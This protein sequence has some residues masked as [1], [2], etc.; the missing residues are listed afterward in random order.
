[1][2]LDSYPS[3]NSPTD[4]AEEAMIVNHALNRQDA[5]NAKKQEEGTTDARG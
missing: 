1:M 3:R 2:H 4:S 5:E